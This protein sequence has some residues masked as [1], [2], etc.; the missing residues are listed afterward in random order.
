MKDKKIILWVLP[1]LITNQSVLPFWGMSVVNQEPVN[2]QFD[3]SSD[4]ENTIEIN[5]DSNI[6][7][8]KKL[9]RKKF[10]EIEKRL[11]DLEKEQTVFLNDENKVQL[12]MI[13]ASMS[14]GVLYGEKEIF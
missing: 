2:Y 14:G 10:L 8:F 11:A 9:E 4:S 13:L 7:Y 12:G 1:F 3:V 6:N 5:N